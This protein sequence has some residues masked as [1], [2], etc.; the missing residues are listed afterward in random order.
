LGTKLRVAPEW[1]TAADGIFRIILVI[2]ASD[3][4]KSSFC[5]HLA[6]AILERQNGVVTMDADIGQANLSPPAAIT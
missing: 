6:Q 2:G 1:E 4:G 3:L 5:Q